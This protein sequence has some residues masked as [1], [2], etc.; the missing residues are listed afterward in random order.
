MEYKGINR[1]DFPAWQGW[2]IIDDYAKTNTE[3]HVM[4][5]LCE[6]N[7]EL[8]GLVAEFYKGGKNESK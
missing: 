1:S 4:I 6:N 3:A 5:Q 8:Q 7:V 2:R